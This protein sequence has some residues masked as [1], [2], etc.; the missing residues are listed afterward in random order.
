MHFCSSRDLRPRDTVQSRL[1]VWYFFCKSTVAE[2]SVGNSPHKCG[3]SAICKRLFFC[4]DIDSSRDKPNTGAREQTKYRKP[5]SREGEGYHSETDRTAI[6][7][8]ILKVCTWDHSDYLWNR[9]FSVSPVARLTEMWEISHIVG[10]SHENV[11]N[12]PH[13]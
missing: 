4:Y 10:D 6:D 2:E 7:S 13:G 12:S 3:V 9:A 8:L 1:A 11:G 5:D